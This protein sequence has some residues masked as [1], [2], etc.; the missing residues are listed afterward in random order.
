[1]SKPL[2]DYDLVGVTLKV[3]SVK[4]KLI[5][6]A[7][8]TVRVAFGRGAVSPEDALRW[9]EEE[10]L[11]HLVRDRPPDQEC[12]T[13]GQKPC[14]SP[15]FCKACRVA[16][17][18]LFREGKQR[19]QPID[20]QF[21]AKP[22]RPTPRSTVDALIHVL[23]T[24]GILAM[25]QPKNRERWSRCDERARERLRAFVGRLKAEQKKEAAANGPVIGVSVSSDDQKDNT[26]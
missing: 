9:I 1:M 4:S 16:D 18:K 17:F 14:A 7:F 10:G 11:W 8:D 5:A 15:S 26:A 13:C 12:L 24:E 22:S 23:R 20:N 2:S 19:P 21:V 3:A 25:K 6:N